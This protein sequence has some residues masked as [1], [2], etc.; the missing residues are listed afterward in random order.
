MLSS[1]RIGEN[2]RP[3]ENCQV[4][5]G[6]I[7]S[8]AAS[9]SKVVRH[10]RNCFQANSMPQFSRNTIIE[11]VDAF[12]FSTHAQ[13]HRLILKFSLQEADRLGGIEPRKIGIM[14]YLVKN[15]DKR[16]PSGASLILEL[17][18]FELE[19]RPSSRD[20]RY[21]PEQPEEVFPRLVNSLKRDGYIVEDN[22]LKAML[23]ESLQVAEIET[24]LESL[25]DKFGFY[26]AKGHF[27]Q[28][29]SA[30]T[31]GDWASANAQLRT[32][33]E[34]LFDS[35]SEILGSDKDK[36][37][38]SHQRREFLAGLEPPFFLHDLNEWESGN[39][40]GFVQGF[41]RRLHPEGS[42]PGLSDEED[43]TFRLHL[44]MIVADHFLRR[45]ENRVES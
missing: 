19:K 39:K 14:Q 42:H 32:F 1:A 44:V 5:S 6:I 18:E 9:L 45:L 12:R 37:S 13:I 22:R 23:P 24:E 15:P 35:I 17:I 8:W 34:S 25:L 28:A 7:S 40:G 4:A 41:W 27:E 26:T 29:A 38:S 2:L 3:I 43:S 36:L 10:K 21:P 33:I 16:G 11:L 30:H 31:R 20:Q